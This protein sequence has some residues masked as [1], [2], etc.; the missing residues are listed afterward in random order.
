[1]ESPRSGLPTM[2][3]GKEHTSFS[4]A[5][6]LYRSLTAILHTPNADQES[7]AGDDISSE[8]GYPF[9]EQR[10]GIPNFGASLIRAGKAEGN[11]LPR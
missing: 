9:G 8:M 11:I 4:L 5:A 10:A 2:H 3:T 1:M 7:C 6:S